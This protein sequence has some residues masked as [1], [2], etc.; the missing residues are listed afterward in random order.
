LQRCGVCFV[1]CRSRMLYCSFSLPIF[2][3]GCID[4]T[5]LKASPRR[6]GGGPTPR[7]LARLPRLGVQAVVQ[8]LVSPYRFKNHDRHNTNT[9]VNYLYAYMDKK[10]SC[11]CCLYI[12]ALSTYSSPC[13]LSN[14]PLIMFR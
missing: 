3:E 11:Y 6:P 7:R 1:E 14:V 4:T 9:Q 12:I 8:R 2:V 13:S 5:V 10:M